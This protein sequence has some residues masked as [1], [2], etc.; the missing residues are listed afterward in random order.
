MV[1]IIGYLRR[2]MK[3]STHANKLNN[4]QHIITTLTPHTSVACANTLAPTNA[5]NFP[6]AAL[7]PLRVDRQCSEY[8]TDGNKKVVVFGP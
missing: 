6:A 3:V 4:P 5:P 1:T 8:V 7:I 2:E